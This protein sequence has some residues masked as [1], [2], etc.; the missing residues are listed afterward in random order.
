M[1]G[2]MLH[3]VLVKEYGPDYTVKDLATIAYD[4]HVDWEEARSLTYIMFGIHGVMMLQEL[5]DWDEEEDY[6][7]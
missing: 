2:D 3:D 5:W 1:N 7:C 6:E 4:E